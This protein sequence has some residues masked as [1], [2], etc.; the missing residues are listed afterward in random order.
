MPCLSL[1]LPD[2]VLE[3]VSFILNGIA[4]PLPIFHGHLR[5]GVGGGDV[6]VSAPQGHW[7][8]AP[9]L[10]RLPLPL[11]DGGNVLLYI[12]YCLP[13]RHF[14][15]SCTFI[16]VIIALPLPIYIDSLTHAPPGGYPLVGRPGL[17][18]CCPAQCC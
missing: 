10:E 3:P 18:K 4:V 16:K 8:P 14:I 11:L 2:T 9:V 5:P 13:G 17:E 15:N 1:I 12:R 7:G 6:V